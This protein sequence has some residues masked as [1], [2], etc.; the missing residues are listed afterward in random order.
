[1][2]SGEDYVNVPESE[3]SAEASLGRWLCAPC[4]FYSLSPPFPWPAL[5]VTVPLDLSS[6]DGS[7]EYVNVSQE[8]QPVSGAEQGM[9]PGGRGRSLESC[10]EQVACGLNTNLPL[11]F[12]PSHCDSPGSGR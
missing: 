3:D 6:T 4:M 7:R 10:L 11:P 12:P 1:M 9:Y 5:P 8:L 2:E